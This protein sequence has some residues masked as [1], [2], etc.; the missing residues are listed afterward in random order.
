M[1]IEEAAIELGGENYK[2][3]INA[4]SKLHK[5]GVDSTLEKEVKLIYN[6]YGKISSGVFC[7]DGCDTSIL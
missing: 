4:V 7:N 2:E 1:P 3:L 5:I 6:E